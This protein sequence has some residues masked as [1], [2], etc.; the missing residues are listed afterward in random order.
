MEGALHR[1][2]LPDQGRG[3]VHALPH[4]ELPKHPGRDPL[5]PESILE[6]RAG[7]ASGMDQVAAAY[8]ELFLAT[9][10]GALGLFTAISRLRAVQKRLVR[11]L[12]E[13]GLPPASRLL[14]SK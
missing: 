13:A 9:G 11:P 3:S 7:L 2:A 8:R 10:G 4:A 6:E 5:V 1:L 12:A 14:H